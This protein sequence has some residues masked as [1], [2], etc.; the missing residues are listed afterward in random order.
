LLC[1]PITTNATRLRP[2]LFEKLLKLVPLR[3]E[4]SMPEVSPK[5]EQQT[6]WDIP[7][8][9]SS[10]EADFGHS[11]CDKPDGQTNGQ[12]GQEVAHAQVF[13]PRAKDKGLQT[14]VTSGL[15]GCDS[16][17][18]A[19]LQS[20][21]ESKCVRRLD[22]AGST[23]FNLTWKRKRTP[24]GRSYLERAASA[25]HTSGSD[26]TSWPTP[27]A[28]DSE[29][30]GAHRGKPDTLHSQAN[31]AA[32][33]TPAE[34]D[35][36]TANQKSFAERGGGK[37]GEQLQNQ[38]KLLAGW[39]TPAVDSFRSRSGNRIDEMGL[40]Q[41]ARTIP[42]CPSGPVRLTAS[43][44]MLTGSDAGT[45]NSGQLNP[46]MSG[47]LMSIPHQWDLFAMRAAATLKRKKKK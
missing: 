38:V 36:R 6:L 11:R 22:T 18:S 44:E 20:F 3:L 27:K 13:P 7:K 42:E 8:R 9:I 5:Y 32:W 40:D 35:Y 28:E 33:A 31:L 29:C 14:L 4:M 34:R 10:L 1:L 47:W 39:P 21:L 16:S 2:K 23:L 15:I 26:F 41:M 24:L 43:G 46:S 17:A 19:T 25:R 12:C 45:V 30:A 37:K